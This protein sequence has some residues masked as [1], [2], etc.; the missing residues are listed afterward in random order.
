MFSKYEDLAAAVASNAMTADDANVVAANRD[1][2][3]ADMEGDFERVARYEN[4]VRRAYGNG[5]RLNTKGW[6][7]KTLGARN[8]GKAA[9]PVSGTGYGNYRRERLHGR[10]EH[11]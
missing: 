4:G 8:R 7:F 5:S 9:L 11:V 2:A 3:A 1:R 10:R 6:G